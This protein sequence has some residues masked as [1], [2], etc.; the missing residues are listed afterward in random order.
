MFRILSID[1]WRYDGCWQW[2]AW[3]NVGNIDTLPST[4]RSILK[5]IRDEGYLTEYSKGRVCIEDD[6]YNIVICDKGDR[7]PLYAIE[8]GNHY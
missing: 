1:A 7:R 3:Y 5:L 2:N 8:Y 4:N 6:G